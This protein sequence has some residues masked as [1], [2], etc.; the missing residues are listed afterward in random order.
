MGM[1]VTKTGHHRRPVHVDPPRGTSVDIQTATR[2]GG[3]PL[4][5][6]QDIAVDRALARIA[7]AAQHPRIGD[8]Y[9][10]SH[11][12]LSANLSLEAGEWKEKGFAPTV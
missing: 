6:D 8:Q 5:L 9:P 4:T 2:H 3:D 11:R 10:V 7:G 12:T 1:R